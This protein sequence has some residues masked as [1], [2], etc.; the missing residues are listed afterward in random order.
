M[1][2]DGAGGDRSRITAPS[3]QPDPLPAILSAITAFGLWGI[4][5][6]YWKLVE[7]FGSDVVVCQRLVWTVACVLPL[8]LVTREWPLWRQAMRT[9][10]LL[11]AHGIAAVLLTFNWS[12]FIWA[13]QHGHIVEASLGYFL[14]PLLNVAIGRLLLGEAL[15]RWRVISITLAAAGVLLQMWLVGRLPWIALSLA[16]TFA[17]YGLARKQSP[18]SSLSGLA[19][20]SV[21]I[22]PVALVGLG[23]MLSTGRPVAGTGS[24]MDWLLMIG[25]GA[26][27]T[28][29][30]L[31]FGHAAK[32]L[33]FTTLG[34]LQFI[35]PTG[36][37][38]IGSLVYQEPVTFWVL[39]SFAF[40]WAGVAVFC[41]EA[42]LGRKREG[43]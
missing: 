5:P 17:L 4:I 7:R 33:R 6:I 38:L 14:N 29:P 42:A 31:A 43:A 27:T 20:E 1:A 19:M 26:C 8:L 28:A 39:V 3:A 34:L 22:L 30:L 12:L 36:Q 32:Y 15:S 13:N 10:K 18:L 40:I 41:A 9:P 21:L 16:V 11:R 2:V 23:W 35:A 25:A 24:A 37:F